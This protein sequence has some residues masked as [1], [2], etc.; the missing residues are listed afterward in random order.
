MKKL[1]IILVSL[2]CLVSCSDFLE[3][4]PKGQIV[5]KTTSDFR[6]LLDNADTRYSN[7]LSQT[8]LYADVVSDNSQV[9][10]ETWQE[11]I[12]QRSHLKQL[13]SFETQVWLP[14]GATGDLVWKNAYYISTLVSNILDEL[15]RADDNLRLQ[16]QLAAEAK[17]HRAYAYLTLINIYAKH[18]N[19]STASSDMGVPLIENPVELPSLERSSVKKVYEF[20]L[21][22]L[23][24]SVDDLPDNVSGQFV[25]RPTKTAAYAI[26]ART[27]LYMGDYENA[28][29]YADK[30]LAINAFLYDYNTIYT[31]N[32][33]SDN[34]IGVSRTS[35]QEILLHK[36]TTKGGHLSEYLQLDSISFNKLYSD[37]KIIDTTTTINYDLRRPL[38]FSGLTENGKLVSSQPSYVFSD[39]GHRYS[40]DNDFNVDYTPITTSEMYVTRAEANAR[41]GNLQNALD[42][43]NTLRTHRFITGSYT[44]LTLADLNNSQQDVLDEVLLERRRE[45]Y[46]KDLRLFDIKRLALGVE[47]TLGTETKSIPANDSKLVWPVHYEYLDLNP[48]IGQFPR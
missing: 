27:Y 1:L 28:A 46:G 11:W 41:L 36:T 3:T 43:I 26:L 45:L 22:D 15:P 32:A 37:Y 8:S 34:L 5:A 29:L 20:I 17:V 6:L 23:L 4:F 35:D 18:Y 7:N 42:D 19:E 30:S 12:D 24:S 47:H 38:W 40:V 44:S 33:S 9:T 21:E 2:T 25:H 13:Y 48:E 14:D 10:L 16:Y 31:G 39:G